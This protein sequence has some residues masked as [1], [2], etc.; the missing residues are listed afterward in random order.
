MVVWLRLPLRLCLLLGVATATRISAPDTSP[1]TSPLLRLIKEHGGGAAVAVGVSESGLR[2]LVT[3]RACAPGDVLLE[4]PLS[5]CIAD[6]A[7]DGGAPLRR[8]APRWSWNLPWNVQL[9]LSVLEQRQQSRTEGGSADPFLDSWPAEPPPLPTA[10]GPEE[11]SLSSDPSL[12]TKAD[13]AFFWIDEQYWI[14]KERAEAASTVAQGATDAGGETDAGWA[15]SSATSSDDTD[16]ADSSE[17]S[18]EEDA[19]G[20][21]TAPVVSGED[22]VSARAFRQAMELVWSRCL[23]LSAGAHGV[24]RLLVPLLDLA[25]HDAFPS[26]MYAYANSTTCGPAIRLHA[27]RAMR[28]GDEVTITYGEHSATHFALYYGFVPEPNPTDA[29]QLTL[30]DVLSVVPAEQLPAGGVAEAL[31][32]LA[33]DGEA[34]RDITKGAAAD[35]A[36]DVLLGHLFE[37]RASGPS[38]DLVNVLCRVLVPPSGSTAEATACRAVARVASAIERALW[39]IEDDEE[40]E[41]EVEADEAL[42]RAARG[43]A[44]EEDQEEAEDEAE[45]LSAVGALLVSL[46]LSRRRLLISVRSQMEEVAAACDDDPVEGCAQLAAILAAGDQPPPTYPVLDTLPVE[47][48]EGWATRSWDWSSGAWVDE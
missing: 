28:P 45:A 39:E 30:N 23:R 19:K 9:A 31:K 41:E 11:L 27:A 36:P 33:K 3:Q 18:E 47:E 14:A 46:R 26:A 24:R 21:W 35:M 4:V 16:A 32:M 12:S 13:E 25:N 22:F 15:I 2:G 48:M 8:A 42:L 7:E 6:G 34:A 44:E 10:C 17:G 40:A 1:G 5:L 37:L 38:A 29:L 20:S 43:E